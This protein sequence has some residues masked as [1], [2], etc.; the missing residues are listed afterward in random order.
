LREFV[1]TRA[2]VEAEQE[3]IVAVGDGTEFYRAAIR[4]LKSLAPALHEGD[5]STSHK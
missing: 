3:L 4:Q 1:L 5:N 2:C